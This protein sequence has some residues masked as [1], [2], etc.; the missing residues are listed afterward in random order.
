MTVCVRS[1]V[2]AGLGVVLSAFAGQAA[3]L[4]ILPV[5]PEL[6]NVD[7]A[8]G[9]LTFYCPGA[10]T[11][12][13]LELSAAAGGRE[14]RAPL[15]ADLRATVAFGALAEGDYRLEVRLADRSTRR[16]FASNAYPMR[17]TAPVALPPTAKRLNN[18]VTELG[19]FRAKGGKVRFTNPRDGWV[20]VRGGSFETMRR[21]P[22]GDCEL[23]VPVASC[24]VRLVKTIYH[25]GLDVSDGSRPDAWCPFSEDFHR[26]WVYGTFN[27]FSGN[28]PEEKVRELRAAGREFYPCVRMRARDRKLRGDIGAMERLLDAA[29][30]GGPIDVDEMSMTLEGDFNPNFGEACW[31]FAEK[32]RAEPIYCCW[33]DVIDNVISDPAS[34]ASALSSVINSGGGRGFIETEHYLCARAEPKAAFA[35]IDRV[36]DFAR[37]VR[38]LMPCAPRHVIYYLGGYLWPGDWNAWCSP[39]PDM[40]AYFAMFLKRLATDPEFADLG[41]VGFSRFYCDEETARFACHAIRHYCIEGNTDDLGRTLRYRYLPGLLRN[42]DFDKGFRSWEAVP[43]AEGSLVVAR[44][45]K[46]GRKEQGR[47]G[48]GRCGDDFAL[49]TRNAAKP[50]VLRQKVTGLVPGETYSLVYATADYDDVLK[51]GAHPTNETLRVTLTNA[52]PEPERSYDASWPPERF[53]SGRR[54]KGAVTLSHKV[55]FT[56]T[57]AETTV[58]FSDWTADGPGGRVGE[59]R[60]LNYVGMRPYFK[61]VEP[62]AVA[63]PEA[64]DPETFARQELDAWLVRLAEKKPDLAF[65]VGCDAAADFPADR[66]FLAGTDGFAVRR[67]GNNVFIFGGTPRGTLYGVYAFLERNSD[68]VFARPD[69]DC[70]T[71]WSRKPT[72]EP[73]A[74]DFRERP[75]LSVRGWGM[76]AARADPATHLWCARMRCNDPPDGWTRKGAAELAERYGFLRTAGGGHNLDKFMPQALFED[77]PEYFCEVD[78]QRVKDVNRAQLCFSNLD[79]ARVVGREAVRMLGELPWLPDSLSIKHEDNTTLCECAACRKDIVLPDGRTVA[80]TDQNFR[81]T[82]FFIWMNEVMKTIRPAYPGVRVCTFGYQFTAPAPAVRADD[83]LDISFCPYVKNDKHSILDPEN[84]KWKRRVDDWARQGSTN[85]IWREYFG[86]AAEFPRP[87]ADVVAKDLCYVNGELSVSRIYSENQPDRKWEMKGGGFR[88]DKWDV[89]AMEFWVLTRLMWNPYQDVDALRRDYVARAYRSAA[90]AIGR[91]YGLIRKAWYADPAV[92][93]WNES[94]Y[95]DHVRYIVRGGIAE[96]CEAALDEAA[97][98]ADL[99]QVKELV[100]RLRARWDDWRAHEGDFET[101]ELKVPFVREAASGA[102]ARA[103]EMTAFNEVGKLR[104]APRYGTS[105]RLMH[106]GKSLYVR[107]DCADAAP[108][109]AYAK[110]KA[111]KEFF[112][113]GDHVELFLSGDFGARGYYHLALDIHGNRYDSTSEKDAEA[114]SCAWEG[115]AERTAKGFAF[116]FVLPFRSFGV[117]PTVNNRI[118]FLPFRVYNHRHQKKEDR[119]Y[120]SWRGAAAH[121]QSGFGDLVLELE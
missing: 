76:C 57:A 61:P 32:G 93:V 66:A 73:S 31:R 45:E 55:V 84:A 50:N 120:I 96:K 118:Q 105:A 26:K 80:T 60:L 101:P 72:F 69:A 19:V 107:L 116:T 10:P 83:A 121:Q 41:G 99:P 102:W 62:E 100:R 22:R 54:P 28:L 51:P 110:P 113:F 82:Q 52:T 13:V 37:S 6:A 44:R 15:G 87:L 89:S 114:F 79:G 98:T 36:A 2:F 115:K 90:P 20:H 65:K 86:C 111:A 81:S 27:C 12:A 14:A 63:E 1:V 119:A 77:H 24:T 106:D 74:C 67:R 109:G 78:G 38:R 25:G 85:L 64:T 7:P 40:K 47:I 46:Y 92:S 29:P 108:D 3:V 97:R 103:A 18:F 21:F 17:V 49:F 56:A 35:E 71:V 94:Q 9:E 59:R 30:R 42:G 68:L 58:E 8:K 88:S 4:R 53:P 34:V 33:C 117:K 23:E 5:D 95:K 70:G 11:N 16:T 112:P 75:V 48:G 91:F 39:G 104:E 43:A